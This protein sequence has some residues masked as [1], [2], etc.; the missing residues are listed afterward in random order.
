MTEKL[1]ALVSYLG[2]RAH[3]LNTNVNLN[4]MCLRSDPTISSCKFSRSKVVLFSSPYQVRSPEVVF[5]TCDRCPVRPGRGFSFC[6]TRMV[7]TRRQGVKPHQ[8]FTDSC[9]GRVVVK[10][11]CQA[12]SRATHTLEFTPVQSV[13]EAET[14]HCARPFRL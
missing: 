1:C 7:R 10:G 3:Q 5:T 2:F 9:A 13:T 8:L 14:V 11:L 12:L 4:R 6:L